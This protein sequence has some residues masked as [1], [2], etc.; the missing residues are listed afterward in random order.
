VDIIGH[1]I[2]LVSV[3]DIQRWSDGTNGPL[4]SRCFLREEL[5]EVGLGPNRFESLAG[6]F[7]AKEAVLKALGT[8]V[9]NGVG[10][11]DVTIVRPAGA[12]PEVRLTGGAAEAAQRLGVNGWHLSISHDAGM[13]IASAIAVRRIS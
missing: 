9:G 5:D 11:T 8:G 6:K 13:A 7:A 3:A 4:V 2:D 1:G 10:L 12:P